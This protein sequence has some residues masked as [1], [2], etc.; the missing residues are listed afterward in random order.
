MLRIGLTGGAGAGKSTVARR[1]A[2]HGA[3]VV[4]ADV[5]AREVV[6]PGSPGLAAVVEEF[7][8]SVLHEDGTLDRAGLAA[9]A[10]SSPER[11][12]A[13]ESITHPRI[14]ARTR[15]LFA[16]AA[17]DAVLVHDVPLLVEKSLGAAYHLVV[18]VHAPEDE[19]IRRLVGRG[20][21]EADA[22]ARLAAQASDDDRRDVADVWLD[23]AGSRADVE[24]RVDRLWSWRLV[25]YEE[26]VRAGR[27]AA[28]SDVALV[29]PDPAWPHQAVRAMDRVAAATG[30]DRGALHHVGPTAVPGV[31]APDVLDLQLV[32]DSL[33]SADKLDRRLGHAG[34]AHV[35][36]DWRDDEPDGTAPVRRYGSC[37]PGRPITLH[38]RPPGWSSRHQLLLRDWL[39]ANASEREDLARR[40]EA[41][42]RSG[43]IDREAVG[44][45]VRESGDRAE[46]WAEAVG[47]HPEA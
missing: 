47:W 22:R 40:Q 19:R 15:E 38:L 27:P 45:W 8:T 44:R 46:V 6:A 26:N 39:R 43:T 2:E 36:G 20:L 28:R 11:R 24:G 9:V 3:V 34:Y 5:L 42:V 29:R 23:N 33:E 17:E 13:L 25:P 16:A 10:F 30:V 41:A 1:L 31:P 35:P 18:V 32:V 21:S 4:D 14:A 7:G 37:D 12:L